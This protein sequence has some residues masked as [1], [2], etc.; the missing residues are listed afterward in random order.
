MSKIL[1][2]DCGGSK[3]ALTIWQSSCAEPPRELAALTVPTD[4]ADEQRL[5][6]HLRQLCAGYGQ[7]IEAAVLAAAGSNSDA[8]GRVR[9]TNNPCCLDLAALRAGLPQIP[10]WAVLNDL[11][12]FAYALPV[13]ARQPDMLQTVCAGAPDHPGLSGTCLAA[14]AGTGLGVA[15]RLPG[16]RVI[17]T[18]AGHCS[19]APETPAQ[20]E[21]WQKMRTFIDRPCNEDLLSGRGLVN[22]LR[23]CALEQPALSAVDCRNLQP[24]EVTAIA[25]GEQP[26]A[27]EL[28]AA[29][30]QTFRLFSEAA[31]QAFSNL[32]LGYLSGGGI[33]LGG[34]VIV[35]IGEL[36]DRDIFRHAF[37]KFCPFLEQLA[38]IPIYLVRAENTVS[39][40][41]ACYA[42]GFLLG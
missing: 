33:Y 24:A 15:V 29:C 40:G 28:A 9:L 39:L 31:G 5:L 36:F 20:I 7:E 18:E 22:I 27:P 38:Q 23:A 42:E 32:A 12:A 26:A 30:R 6:P 3:C 41:A 13:I 16:G 19:F 35:K 4:F 8:E 14:A 11:A 1:T 34:G 25:R 2:I 37:L 21:L 17:N 10:R